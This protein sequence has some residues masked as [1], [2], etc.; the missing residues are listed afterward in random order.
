MRGWFDFYVNLVKRPARTVDVIKKYYATLYTSIHTGRVEHNT[1]VNARCIK[2]LTFRP[3]TYG[4]PKYQ[5][6]FCY[7][8]VLCSTLNYARIPVYALVIDIFTGAL[9]YCWV[10]CLLF[11]RVLVPFNAKFFLFCRINRFERAE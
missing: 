10:I 3:Q 1:R 9:K 11:S 5:T 8:C 2:Y 7:F 4:Y 6:S